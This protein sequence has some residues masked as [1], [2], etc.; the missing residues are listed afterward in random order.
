MVKNDKTKYNKP[1]D[2]DFLSKTLS[3]FQNYM[4]NN[5]SFD[6]SSLDSRN[7]LERDN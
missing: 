5:E 1:H 7:Q 2:V 6:N 3:E 4:F